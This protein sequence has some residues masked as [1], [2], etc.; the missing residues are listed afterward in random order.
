ME[1]LPKRTTHALRLM[2]S[3]IKLAHSV[4]A[5]PFAIFAAFLAG[6]NPQSASG[7]GVSDWLAFA[8]K[9]ALIVVC[10]VLART[11]AMLVNRLVD[12]RI[13]AANARTSRRA[14]AS[15]ALSPLLGWI[16][17][18]ACAAMLAGEGWVFFCRGFTIPPA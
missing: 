12:R 7:H 4:F 17:A 18:L 5:L 10:M 16:V 9:L 6:P 15:G 3:D 1:L 8:L 13:D 11:W 14:F 2:A